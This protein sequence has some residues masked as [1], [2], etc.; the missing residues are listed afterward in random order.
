MSIVPGTLK[1]AISGIKLGII[2]T[3]IIV[4]NMPGDADERIHM[5]KMSRSFL[6][7]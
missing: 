5:R 3:K 2:I 1:I 7:E 4:K 6:Q